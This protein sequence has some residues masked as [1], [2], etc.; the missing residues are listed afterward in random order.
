MADDLLAAFQFDDTDLSTGT[1]RQVQTER[2]KYSAR[3]ENP[4]VCLIL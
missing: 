1:T 2:Q 3:N 4:L